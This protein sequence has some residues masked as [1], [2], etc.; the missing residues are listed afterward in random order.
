MATDAVSPLWTE[1]GHL[2]KDCNNAS[3]CNRYLHMCLKKGHIGWLKLR[4]EA[5]SQCS[6][7]ILAYITSF[8]TRIPGHHWA[9]LFQ[10]LLPINP[11][12]YAMPQ[13]KVSTLFSA[14]ERQ[15]PCQEPDTNLDLIVNHS[16]AEHRV[17]GKLQKIHVLLG[18]VSIQCICSLTT[19]VCYCLE[20]PFWEYRA[21][22]WFWNYFDLLLESIKF[23]DTI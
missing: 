19:C 17:N 5:C 7:L 2:F 6:H 11:L 20:L 1:L 4:W 8:L 23:T 13:R 3:S 15:K 14:R 12:A 16:T 10:L 21:L 22:K 9:F 18:P